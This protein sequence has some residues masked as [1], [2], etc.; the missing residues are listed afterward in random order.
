MSYPHEIRLNCGELQDIRLKCSEVPNHISLDVSLLQE[1]LYRF[2]ATGEPYEIGRAIGAGIAQ[3]LAERGWPAPLPPDPTRQA[4]QP[5]PD[6]A[7]TGGKGE[8]DAIRS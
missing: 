6:A 4:T 2:N 8:N 3:G 1:L 5:A 7:P